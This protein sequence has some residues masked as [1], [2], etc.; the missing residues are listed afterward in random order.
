MAI[1]NEDRVFLERSKLRKKVLYEIKKKPQT[2]SFLA[3]D[4]DKH[5]ETMSRVLLDLQRNKMAKCQNPEDPSFRFYKIPP[6]GK[7]ILDE[8]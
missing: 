8:L 6:K 1:K 4:L 5:R 2:A 7:K 3:K